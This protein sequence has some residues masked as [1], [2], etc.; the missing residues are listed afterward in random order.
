MK[1]LIAL[2]LIMWS[3]DSTVI[4]AEVPDARVTHHDGVDLMFKSVDPNKKFDTGFVPAEQGI[5]NIAKALDQLIKR[6]PISAQKVES[7]KNSGRVLLIY[8]PD[9]LRNHNTGGEAVALFLPD[10]LQRTSDRD[11]KK[12]F[13][14]VVG[15]HGVK[16]PTDELA[17]VLAHELV[18]H[19]VQHQRGRLSDIRVL[20]AE[21]EAYLYGEIAIQDLGIDKDTLEMVA[22][23]KAVEENFCS[24]FRT[25]M[26]KSHP[27]DMALWDVQNPNVPELL[28][29]FEAYLDHSKR[30]GVTGKS[31]AASKRM[32]QE[33]RKRGLKDASPEEIYKFAKQLRIGDF[34]VAPTLSE[35]FRYFKL[36]AERGHADAQYD[37]GWIYTKGDGVN[38]IPGKAFAWFRKAA[39]QGRAAAQSRLGW[40]YMKGNGTAKDYDAAHHWFAKAAQQ[41]YANAYYYLGAM[42]RLGL[43]R[44]KNHVDAAGWYRKGAEA[45][46]P[47]SQ[48]RYG[49]YIYRG[50]GLP[51]N[52]REAAVWFKK[53]ANKDYANAQY[54]LGWMHTQGKGVDKNLATAESWFQKS[55][56]NGHAK[57]QHKLGWIYTKGT[58]LKK[59]PAKA[60]S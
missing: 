59:D 28:K 47:G 22:L 46:H 53:A 20:D 35:S 39:E 50:V 7:L 42:H 1:H 54:R 52:H 48:Y 33:Q 6:S 14:V 12:T 3:L 15:R 10:F 34:G 44:D 38:K 43:G 40:L 37:L 36:A 56:E 32:L 24:D 26:R 45:D 19:G 11:R 60:L 17:A 8:F 23:R 2:A 31:L 18:G 30:E 25:Y 57:A 27:D 51:K 21:C 29:L 41:K 5:Q 4:A 13:L 49:W 9:N 55:A 58:G 16:W